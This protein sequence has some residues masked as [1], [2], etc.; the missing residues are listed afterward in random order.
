MVQVSFSGLMDRASGERFSPD[1]SPRVPFGH[2]LVELVHRR[3]GFAECETRRSHRCGRETAEGGTACFFRGER[4]GDWAKF[5]HREWETT[6]D[7]H[8]VVGKKM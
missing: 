7:L 1:P 6:A 5:Q 8:G 2:Q 4:P 3:V